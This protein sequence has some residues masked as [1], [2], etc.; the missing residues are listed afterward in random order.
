M[1]IVRAA[2]APLLEVDLT[3]DELLAWLRTQYELPGST[4]LRLNLISAIGGQITGPSGGSDELADGVDRPLLRLL[5]E[6]ADVVLV[7]AAS[8]RAGGYPLPARAPLAVLTASGDLGGHR[9]RADLDPAR[10]LVL[11]PPSAVDRVRDTLGVPGTIVPIA[12]DPMADPGAA[13]AALHDRGLGRVLCE[14]GGGIASRLLAAGLVTE[15]CHSSAP[16]VT[17]PGAPLI[18]GDVPL[19]TARLDLLLLDETDRTYARWRFADP[20]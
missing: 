16:L 18:T 2:P 13:L 19:T 11:C 12:G 1:R 3:G 9:L 7:G 10:L 20:A 8:L 5:R 14:G 15:F 6:S 4:W 17:A